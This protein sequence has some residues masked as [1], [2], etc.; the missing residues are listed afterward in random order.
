MALTSEQIKK[1]QEAN[2]RFDLEIQKRKQEEVK[3]Q[4]SSFIKEITDAI[5]RIE[6]K[7]PEI[8][9]PDINIPETKVPEAKVKVELPEI[10]VPEPKITVNVAPP[11]VNIPEVKVPETKYP[12]YPKFPKI[13][14][15]EVTV[16]IP[17][18]K[19]PKIE[20]PKVEI[21][22]NLRVR[23]NDVDEK[24]PLPV[25]LTDRLG[26]PYESV[27]SISG[28]GRGASEFE[29]KKRDIGENHAV[30]ITTTSTLII[31]KGQGRVGLFLV[32]ESLTDPIYLGLNSSVTTANGFP[33]TANQAVNWD[34][35]V[36][37]IYGIIS[38][39]AASS[40]ISMRILTF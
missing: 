18:I 5:G 25:I 28:G 13:P 6:I 17:P 27:M 23:L 1:L 21:P 8:K 32:H 10:V 2:S 38:T 39:G 9:I 35:Y 31:E 24:H 34:D 3:K 14:K 33:I 36:G 37:E 40:T 29:R 11:S 22:N 7:V 12:P 20:I 26:K 16:N 4:N 19:V 15:P 30:L